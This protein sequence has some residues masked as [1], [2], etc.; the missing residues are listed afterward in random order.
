[1]YP[2]D[3]RMMGVLPI[4]KTNGVNRSSR[5]PRTGTNAALQNDVGTERRHFVKGAVY[6]TVHMEE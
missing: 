1:M 2:I 5:R 4:L 6:D 3:V